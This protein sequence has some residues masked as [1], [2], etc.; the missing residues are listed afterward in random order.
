MIII[1]PKIMVIAQ[2]KSNSN[3]NACNKKEKN[4]KKNV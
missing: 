2:P 3:M 4:S 1:F